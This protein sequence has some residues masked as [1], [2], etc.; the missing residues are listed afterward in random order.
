[1]QGQV[2]LEL[3]IFVYS[4]YKPAVRLT[5]APPIHYLLFCPTFVLLY[6]EVRHQSKFKYVPLIF[7]LRL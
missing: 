1:M 6:D 2:S 7:K 5:F 4:W 3:R